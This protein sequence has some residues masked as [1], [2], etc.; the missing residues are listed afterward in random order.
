VI[1]ERAPACP[2][3]C[4]PSPSPYGYQDRGEGAGYIVERHESERAGGWRYSEHDGQGRYQAWGDARPRRP[5]PPSVP[6]ASCAA[7]A[8]YAGGGYASAGYAARGFA[9]SA[10]ASGEGEWRD[11]SYGRVYQYSGRDAGGYLV[12]PGKTGQ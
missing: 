9:S 1:Y 8:A 12:W 4:P 6:A 11:G 3:R 2:D 10:Y 7:G 5:C